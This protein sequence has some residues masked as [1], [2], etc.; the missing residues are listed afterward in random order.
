MQ[1][2][3]T[4]LE[5]Y[6]SW[7]GI[8]E[9][10]KSP[11]C[12]SDVYGYAKSKTQIY[13]LILRL[14]GCL[15]LCT[16]STHIVIICVCQFLWV[17]MLGDMH[18][19]RAYLYILKIREIDSFAICF[20]QRIRL[21]RLIA[22]HYNLRQSRPL[23]RMYCYHLSCCGW[24]LSIW[25]FN[26]SWIPQGHLHTY[27]FCDNVWTFILQDALFK[28]EELQETVGRVKIVAC[29]SKLLSQ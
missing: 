4:I 28:S 9:N 20:I 19:F 11:N 25:N 6:D 1:R 29:D 15:L 7:R 23:P 10:F 12:F 16:G 27:R 26:F 17:Q 8:P 18:V 24:N 3:Y 13:V 14:I 22:E 2:S 5:S 21:L